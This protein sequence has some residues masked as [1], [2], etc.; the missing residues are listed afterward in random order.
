MWAVKLFIWQNPT[1]L[2]YHFTVIEFFS[3]LSKLAERAIYFTFRN[4][5]LI[6]QSYL[7]IYWTDF[8]DFFT[9]WKVFCES[10]KPSPVFPIPQGTLP[11]Q[12]ILWQNYLPPALIALSFQNRMA[13]H[14]VNVR[15]NSVNDASILCENFMKFCPVTPE[16]FAGNSALTRPGLGSTTSPGLHVSA[17]RPPT[18]FQYRTQLQLRITWGRR[19]VSTGLIKPCPF[20]IHTYI[21]L[22]S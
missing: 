6:E 3:P 1:F 13:Y 16:L 17:L 10:F 7:R 2:Y 8:Y 4:F 20:T 5:F 21:Q 18:A 15:V 11:W 14:Y 9:K 19:P 12:P 22:Q